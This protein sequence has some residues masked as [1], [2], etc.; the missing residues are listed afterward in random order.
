MRIQH[1][2]RWGRTEKKPSKPRGHTMPKEQRAI[3][4]LFNYLTRR[5]SQTPTGDW[6]WGKTSLSGRRLLRTFTPVSLGFSLSSSLFR[7]KVHQGKERELK[8]GDLE[9]DLEQLFSVLQGEI[10]VTALR[11]CHGL[12]VCVLPL[13]FCLCFV[14]PFT[15]SWAESV[16]EQLGTP[17]Q[18]IK[19]LGS[20]VPIL[21]LSY[22]IALSLAPHVWF[23]LIVLIFILH[24]T[25]HFY[26]FSYILFFVFL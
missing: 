19:N 4:H 23:G 5:G 22:S 10:S 9:G 25:L 12:W 21:P 11:L 17:G 20:T 16:L 6:W 3:F 8:G 13:G 14:S 15:S 26:A 2:Y 18:S 24:H 1:D 7:R